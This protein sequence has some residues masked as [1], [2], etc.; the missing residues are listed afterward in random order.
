MERRLLI[1]PDHRYEPSPCTCVAMPIVDVLLYRV[2]DSV[3]VATLVPFRYRLM[4]LPVRHAS[5]C[6]QR[7][8]VGLV[9]LT[10]I[11]SLE[12]VVE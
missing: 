12:P 8:R 9:A 4:V 11:M 7:F 6:D 2:P 1:Y 3:V 5:R 10:S